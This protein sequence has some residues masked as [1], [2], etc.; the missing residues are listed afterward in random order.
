MNMGDLNMTCM[1][2]AYKGYEIEK[3]TRNTF[4]VYKDGE[5]IDLWSM[6]GHYPKTYKEAKSM[7][8]ALV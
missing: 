2:K 8:D 4:L 6:N 7:I 3:I 1:M 5:M